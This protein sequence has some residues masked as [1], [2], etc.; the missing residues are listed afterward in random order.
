MIDKVWGILTD[1]PFVIP[2]LKNS[3]KNTENNFIW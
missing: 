1:A 2:G 3:V